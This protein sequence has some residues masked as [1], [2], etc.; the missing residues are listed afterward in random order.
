MFKFRH[1]RFES[2][3]RRILSLAILRTRQNY[4]HPMLGT[5]YLIFIYRVIFHFYG[6]E[7]GTFR[8]FVSHTSA[9]RRFLSNNHVNRSFCLIVRFATG[10]LQ[11]VSS[12]LHE[13]STNLSNDLYIRVN[14]I[15]SYLS[16]RSNPRVLHFRT[17]P[18][19]MG[20]LSLFNG[21]HC[22]IQQFPSIVIQRRQIVGRRCNVVARRE[23]LTH[24][25]SSKNRQY[26]SP[27][28]SA[29]HVRHNVNS[30]KVNK[31]TMGSATTL[32]ISRRASAK[33][34]S[35]VFRGIRLI[36]RA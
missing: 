21:D 35:S 28:S 8:E 34:A 14:P 24:H 33:K 6:D 12:V 17:R 2:A 19:P 4:G 27:F 26:H 29:F 25:P 10:L 13:C 1:N 11:N 18:F 22:R 7:F 31:R 32:Q 23:A 3:Y 16:I 15:L 5:L 9:T 30:N 36:V 20:H